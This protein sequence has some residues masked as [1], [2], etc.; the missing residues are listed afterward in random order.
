MKDEELSSDPTV[1]SG[2]RS[3][4]GTDPGHRGVRERASAGD[5]RHVVRGEED[6]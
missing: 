1:R 5:P 6:S 4:H 2:G 3:P